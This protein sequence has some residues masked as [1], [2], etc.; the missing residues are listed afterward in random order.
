MRHLRNIYA[1]RLTFKRNGTLRQDGAD[2]RNVLRL[3]ELARDAKEY[4]KAA[5]LFEEYLPR[6]PK[7]GAIHVQC[8]HMFKETGDYERAEYH[9]TCAKKLMPEDADLALQ[10]GHSIKWLGA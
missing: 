4:R 5:L 2:N 7:P 8:G 6:A 3:A 9:Y 10:F 1:S